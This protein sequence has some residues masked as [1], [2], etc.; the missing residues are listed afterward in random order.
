MYIVKVVVRIKQDA[1]VMCV[2]LCLYA[3]HKSGAIV[4]DGNRGGYYYY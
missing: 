4:A 2:C 1:Y 3:R